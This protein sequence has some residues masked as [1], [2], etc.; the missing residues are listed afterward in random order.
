MDTTSAYFE[1]YLHLL[2]EYLSSTQEAFEYNL[3]RKYN[4][5]IIKQVYWCILISMIMD[6]GA[7]KA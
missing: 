2:L 1:G 3:G 4:L 7:D 5:G 6:D